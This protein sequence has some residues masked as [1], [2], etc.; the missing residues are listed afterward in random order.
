MQPW[1]AEAVRQYLLDMER[2]SNERENHRIWVEWY[3]PRFTRTMSLVPIAAQGQRCLEIGAI[4]YTFTLLMKKLRTYELSLVDFDASATREY[5]E[6]V[7]LPRYQ[8]VHEFVSQRCD[9]EREDLP[10]AEHTFDGVLCCEVL[11]HLT[12]DP[13]RM[14]A[15]IH[16]VLKP[17]GWLILTT[18]NVASLA[19]ILALLHGRNVYTPY[20]VDF[21]PTWR[22]NREYTAAEVRELLEETGF[23]VD[24]L[25]IEDVRPH[26]R[27]PIATRAIKWALRSWYQQDYG[28]QL[29]VRASRGPRFRWHYPRWLFQHTEMHS[30]SQGPRPPAAQKA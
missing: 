28:D 4:P 14:L 6:T 3:L 1:D 27:L 22:H 24:H 16:R 5:C 30:D 17:D 8:E 29:Y 26:D 13:V 12:L 2:P 18:P 15:G 25:S 11:E 7:R 9:V 10:F 20:D 21:G 19:N 23:K